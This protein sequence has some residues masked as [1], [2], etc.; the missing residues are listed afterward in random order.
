MKTI[1]NI[2]TIKV[3]IILVILCFGAEFIYGQTVSASDMQYLPNYSEYN[4]PNWKLVWDDDFSSLDLTKWKVWDNYDQWGKAGS[5]CIDDN[6]SVANGKLKLDVKKETYQC[7][8]NASGQTPYYCFRQKQ[9]SNPSSFAYNYTSGFVQSKC[10]YEVDYGYIEAKIAFPDEPGTTSCFWTLNT[11]CNSIGTNAGEIDIAEVWGVNQVD[12]LLLPKEEFSTNVHL[13]YPD[14]DPLCNDPDRTFDVSILPQSI[15]AYHIYGLEWTPTT[16]KFYFN[17]ILVDTKVN[18]GVVNKVDLLLNNFVEMLYED[19]LLWISFSNNTISMYVDWVRV[20]AP[21]DNIITEVKKPY[22]VN[23]IDDPVNT[24]KKQIDLMWQLPY[25]TSSTKICTVD[26]GTSI[27]YTNSANLSDNGTDHLYKKTINNLQPNTKYYYRV[28]V[29]ATEIYTGNFITPPVNTSQ[30]TT[31]YACGSTIR[32]SEPLSVSEHNDVC[33]QIL[34]EISNDPSSQTLLIQANDF[35]TA[36]NKDFWQ[37]EYF[38]NAN[39]ANAVALRSK[40]PIIGPLGENER[41]LQFIDM[42]NNTLFDLPKYSGQN[43]RDY[44][45]FNYINPYGILIP[46]SGGHVDYEYHHKLEY[47]PV[48][49]C[50]AEVDELTKSSSEV[51]VAYINVALGATTK[52]WKVL[53]FNIPL[54]SINGDILNS[55]TLDVIRNYASTNNAQLVIMGHEDYYA[56]WVDNGI[57]Y[58]ILG[59]GG[60]TTN[61]IDD[62]KIMNQTTSTSKF[63]CTSTVPHF[64]KF[65]VDDNFMYVDIIQGAD[66]NGYSAGRIIEKFAIPKTPLITTNATW[67]AG[68]YPILMGSNVHIYQNSTLI[69]KSE[70]QFDED[71]ALK[72]WHSG[73][74]VLNEPTSILSPYKGFNE[75]LDFVTISGGS[76]INSYKSVYNKEPEY[77]NGVW[78]DGH[79]NSNQAFVNGYADQGYLTMSNGATIKNAKCG[80]YCGRGGILKAYNSNF[81]NNNTDVSMPPYENTYVNSSGQTKIT[82]N[83]TR[84]LNCNFFTTDDYV[85]NNAP[86]RHIELYGVRGVDI[87]G[88]TFTNSNS[89]CTVTSDKGTGIWSS[90]SSYFV[91]HLCTDNSTYPCSSYKPNTFEGLYYGIKSSIINSDKVIQ[92]KNSEFDGCYRGAYLN[93]TSS[94]VVTNNKCTIPDFDP[95]LS[96]GSWDNYPYGLYL[97]GGK[98]FKVEENDFSYSGSIIG[99]RGIIVHNTGPL[100]NQIYKNTFEGLYI[101][102]QPQ[103]NNKDATAATDNGLGLFCNINDNPMYDVWV[104]GKAEYPSMAGVGIAKAQ[105]ISDGVYQYPAGNQFSSRTQYFFDYD[106]SNLDAEGLDYHY[107][108][109]V[110]NMTPLYTSNIMPYIIAVGSNQCPSKINTGN[111]MGQLYDDVYTARIAYNSSKLI[112]DIWKDG[113][114]ED[115]GEEVETTLPWDAY[116]QFNDLMNESPY[117]SDEVLIAFIENPAFTSLM[118]KLL[119]IANPQSSRSDAVMQ[120]IY[121]R[122]PALPQSY[123]DEILAEESTGSQLDLLEDN[124]AADYRLIRSIEEDIKREYR[125][126]TINVWA[127]DSLLALISR[128]KDLPDKY[129]LANLYLIREQY[130]EMNSCLENIPQNYEL[131]EELSVDHTNFISIFEI[132]Q[133][134]YENDKYIGDLTDIQRSNLESFVELQRPLVSQ[135]S[136]A[137]LKRDNPDYIYNELIFEPSESSSRKANPKIN[138]LEADNNKPLFKLYPNPAHDYLTVE[139]ITAGKLYNKLWLEIYDSQGKQ[140]FTKQ[141]QGGDNEE[142][143]GLSDLSSGTYMYSFI[144]DGK[145]LHSDKLN[146]ER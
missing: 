146:I 16:L 78:L 1:I 44:F 94:A 128:Q 28:T 113:G 96:Y 45:P 143:I 74:L 35:V 80:V 144:A 10:N 63:I 89:N 7:P 83:K 42:D 131:T 52:E 27:Y 81:I 124:V 138:S 9:S 4:E 137:L 91:D 71:L 142:L 62:Q 110:A 100:N 135:M 106:Y 145:V 130:A 90:E 57:H 115:L 125:T 121:D 56:H 61:G 85:D 108:N 69:I 53:N 49:F 127:E 22:L 92:I 48:H 64:A 5:V 68:S 18:P 67:D 55:T 13:C 29:S 19:P 134:M 129:E 23:P 141:L 32:A 103:L 95:N 112:L 43:F 87:K 46:N 30:T 36:D 25:G 17:G 15:T 123:I 133:D 34:N 140:V 8:I 60:E 119:M 26:W 50:F 114:V 116:Q 105:Q 31:F 33:E 88:N 6:V 11:E 12:G 2:K 51:G 79:I 132:A 38:R 76:V 86:I 65:K 3:S 126:D 70:I 59:N 77:W 54:K 40:I 118:V 122:I 24:G 41:K 101:G 73:N 21:T 47:G 136:L 14:D 75:N 117:L 39:C 20:Y 98:G 84:I 107:D 99:A 111:G 66:Y 120:A 109:T 82:S 104:S 93:N 139:Y 37:S 97:N 102:I 58:L 72:V